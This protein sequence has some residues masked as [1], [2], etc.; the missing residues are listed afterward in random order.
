MK[1]Y[2][3]KDA[4]RARALLV[5]VASER[6]TITYSELA[7]RLGFQWNHRNPND[8]RLIGELLGEVSLQEYVR[9]RPLLTAVVLRKGGD[10]PGPGFRGLLDFP[11]SDEFCVTEIRRVHDFWA[12]GVAA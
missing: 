8:R 7:Q 1:N 9:G 4:I 3:P 12:W 5:E 11:E 2:S 10:M 6:G